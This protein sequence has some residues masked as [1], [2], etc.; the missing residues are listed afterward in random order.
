[1]S[2]AFSFCV[3]QAGRAQFDAR[4][5]GSQFGGVQVGGLSA[6]QIVSGD[7]GCEVVSRFGDLT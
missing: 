4:R 1:M 3:M 5:S 6:S 2:G 7:T